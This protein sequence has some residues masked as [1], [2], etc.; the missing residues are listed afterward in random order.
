MKIE[1]DP[2]SIRTQSYG[3]QDGSFGW[4]KGKGKDGVIIPHLLV[5][6]RESF[7]DKLMHPMKN[8]DVPEWFRE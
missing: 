5:Y 1:R 4:G 3:V 7:M 6:V 2:V 8:E